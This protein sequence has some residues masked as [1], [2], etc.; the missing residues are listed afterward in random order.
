VPGDTF[1]FGDGT[2]LAAANV[3]GV[4]ALAIAASGDPLAART[5]F[6]QAAQQDSPTFPIRVPRICAVLKRLGKPCP[7]P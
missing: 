1:A 4:L 5:A 7:T 6:F 2:S 3:A